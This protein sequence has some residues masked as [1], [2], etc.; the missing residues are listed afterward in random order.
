[1]YKREEKVNYKK[2]IFTMLS[3]FWL[4]IIF[5]FSLQPAKES[6][7][8]SMEFGKMLVKLIVPEFS[9]ELDDMSD[10]QLEQWDHVLRKCA[11]FMEYLVLGVLVLATLC[12]MQVRHRG[13]VAIGLCS[14]A[15]AVDE[16]IQLFVPGRAGRIS[17][18]LLDS[19]G[20]FTGILV[21]YLFMKLYIKIA[22]D[23]FCKNTVDKG[24]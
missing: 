5:S 16:G 18:I 7:E 6:G 20:A 1:M 21:G 8:T 9:D 23:I 14:V 12:Q 22:R 11:H 24:K 10:V 17:D 3:I 15:A 4:S 2:W 13:L 19:L